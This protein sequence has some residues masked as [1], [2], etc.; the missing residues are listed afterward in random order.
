M[1]LHVSVQRSVD[2]EDGLDTEMV[3][4]SYLIQDSTSGVD[5]IFRFHCGQ[6]AKEAILW[7]RRQ[8]R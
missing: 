5:G 7:F 6:V 8:S 4:G 1:N 3:S 2:D